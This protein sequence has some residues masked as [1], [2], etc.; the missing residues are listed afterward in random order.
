MSQAL[1]LQP[2]SLC[3]GLV[4]DK[5]VAR[6]EALPL[7]PPSLCAFSHCALIVATESERLGARGRTLLDEA[8]M[9]PWQE[10]AAY[11]GKHHGKS[12]QREGEQQ[13]H[14]LVHPRALSG[15]SA[16]APPFIMGIVNVTPDSFSDGG[17]YMDAER[18]VAHALQLQREGAHIIDIGGESTRP[19][20]QNVPSD[21]EQQRV[22]PVI[23][24]CSKQGAVISIDSRHAAT[25][26]AALAAGATMMNDVSALSYDKQALE[27]ARQHEHAHI[28]LMHM[29]GT[30]Q[31]MQ[32]NPYYDCVVLDVYDY[33]KQRI[34][35][36][37]RAGID[38]KRLWIDVG[39]GF[40]KT[41]A[42]NQ[43][44][45]RHVA[46]FHTLGVPMI[47]GASRKRLISGLD[48][49]CPPEKRD[50]GSIAACLHAVNHACQM[51][52]VHDVDKTRQ[53]LAVWRGMLT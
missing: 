23:Q 12:M 18:A 17:L 52:R 2:R 44:L 9:L 36:C 53:A 47:L 20:A 5:A 4:A 40:G 21:D 38:K 1:Y 10:V 13:L 49:D 48:Q 7:A 39:I 35:A 32:D 27:V 42:H 34:E 51:V 8:P 28:V 29:Q 43:A 11:L 50:A 14:A 37:V 41:L 33:L 3:Y 46:L 24:G 16:S 22:L 31:T 30:P 6:K 19:G 15:F 26:K 45:L 25:Q